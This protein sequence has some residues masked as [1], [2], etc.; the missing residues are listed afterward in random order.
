M[1]A[2]VGQASMETVKI[3]NPFCTYSPFRCVFTSDSSP[4]FQ[5]EPEEG[6]MDRSDGDPTEILVRF[7]PSEPTDGITATLVFETDDFKYIYKFV[8]ST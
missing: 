3:V 7:R 6:T 5:C 2:N 4:S 8:G 1:R